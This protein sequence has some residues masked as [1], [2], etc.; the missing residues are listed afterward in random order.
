MD[1][2]PFLLTGALLGS[3]LDSSYAQNSYS[4]LNDAIAVSMATDNLENRA[5]SSSDVEPFLAIPALCVLLYQVVKLIQEETD[6][7]YKKDRGLYID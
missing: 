7:E 5:S 2:K 6:P 1:Y 4:Y 3:T